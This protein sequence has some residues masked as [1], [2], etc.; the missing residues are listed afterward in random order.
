MLTE[1]LLM[2]LVVLILSDVGL[3]VVVCVLVL[4]VEGCLVCVSVVVGFGS[5]SVT[6]VTAR[7]IEACRKF[8][9]IAA[10]IWLGACE[11]SSQ[12]KPIPAG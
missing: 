10:V 9:L 12:L 6:P 8:P 11:R 5:A 4:E 7:L 3:P 2:A 1:W